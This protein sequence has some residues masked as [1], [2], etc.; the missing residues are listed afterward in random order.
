MIKEVKYLFLPAEL[1][2]ERVIM[3]ESSQ[4]A[5][6]DV[7]KRSKDSWRSTRFR[8]LNQGFRRKNSIYWF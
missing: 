3:L 5:E 8:I 2:P 4:P 7:R 6:D 1:N